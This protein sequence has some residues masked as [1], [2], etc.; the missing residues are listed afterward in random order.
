MTPG[1]PMSFSIKGLNT[2]RRGSAQLDFEDDEKA[3]MDLAD[4]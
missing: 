3:N 4:E 2:E 1:N